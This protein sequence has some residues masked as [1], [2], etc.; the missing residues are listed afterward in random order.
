[1]NDVTFDNL[2]WLWLLAVAGGVA[3]VGVY[4]IWQRV[5][6]MRIFATANVIARLAP[7]VSW[8][9]GIIRIS[10]IT[11]ALIALTAAIIGP[12]WG[13]SEQKLYRRGVDVMVLLDVSRSMLARDIAPNRLERAK[14]SIREDLLP[15]LGGDRIGLIAF[16]GS[17]S[18][19]CPLTNDYG[20]F[21][22]ALD[23]IGV[24][25][26][27]RGGTLIGDAIRLARDSFDEKL[28]THKVIVLIT[29][30]E[31]H[32]SFPLE[33]ARKLWDD[34]K[35]P[36]VSVALGDEREGARIPVE[37]NAGQDYVRY[38]GNVV[39]S[40]ANF[41]DL[42][43]IAQVS[44]LS[45]FVPVGTQNFDLGDIYRS[46]IA[47]AMASKQ[48]AENEKVKQPTQYHMFAVAAL[49]LVLIESFLREG[50]RRATLI[51]AGALQK[52]AA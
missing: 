36:I 18:L 33:A 2:N 32:E 41:D 7:P 30:G 34:K 46:K 15:A 5:R 25:S 39:W 20:F 1:M 42:R 45:A 13:E 35:I 49:V 3:V 12:R 43:K 6:A 29:D 24:G 23:D 9:R 31:D 28:D 37:N 44:T 51:R 10:L 26:V 48:L 4:G 27:P 38:Q 11:L 16:A 17:P 22:L 14:L 50:P 40:K 21:R 8:A 19:K 47:P 52:E